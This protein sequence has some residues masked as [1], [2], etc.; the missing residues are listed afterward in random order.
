MSEKK[1]FPEKPRILIICNYYLPGY[2]SGGG[3]RT[4]VHMVERFH[5]RYDFR[6][7][8]LDHDG[9]KI[10]FT[11]VE[12]NDWNEIE[13]AQVFYLSKDKANISKL[14]ELI[15]E[16]KP[17]SIYLNSVFSKLTVFY[18]TLRK[19]KLIPAIKTILAPEGELSGGALKLKS[20]KKKPFVTLA[21]S[22]GLYRNLFWKTT[23]DPEKQE[24]E[25]F[26]GRGGVIFVAP[27]LPSRELLEN[28][29]QDLKPKKNVG[30]VKMIFLSRFM[31]K[32]NFKWLVDNL[33]G[34]EGNLT[35][36]I[37]GPIEDES[38][39]EATATAIAKLPP[40]VKIK[41]G[42][43][44]EYDKVPGKLFEYHFF[45]LPTVGEN[46]GHVFIE[47][48]AAGCPLL[49]SD[50]TPWRDLEAKNVG[51]EV[52]LENPAKWLEVLNYCVNLDQL[53]YTKISENSHRFARRWLLNPE[54]EEDTLKVLEYS[55]TNS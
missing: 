54:V 31:R 40:N 19:L 25:R 17:D 18:L 13:K 10:P 39:W 50:R 20:Y 16:I 45:V 44:L 35:I 8:T 51:W 9:D 24:T 41:Y 55:L 4:L 26:K 3:L 12:I 28:Y 21:K 36:D 1:G 22:A 43:V 14:R 47:A 2:K 6:V 34:F 32:K 5:D 7:I 15:I 23:A 29:R 52:P 38:Y 37:Y 46:F 27:N 48:L 30:E 53:S 33:S 42:G 11:T 49:I